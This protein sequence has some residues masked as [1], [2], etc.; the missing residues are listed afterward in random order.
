MSTFSKFSLEKFKYLNC[1][2]CRVGTVWVLQLFLSQSFLEKEQCGTVRKYDSKY[3]RVQM[4]NVGLAVLQIFAEFLG[5]LL[6]S[7]CFRIA[8]IL[9][10]VL[11][12]FAEILSFL[13][14]SVCF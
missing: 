5:F 4:I 14:V 8:N 9:V 12:I 1:F 3:Q 6:V 7:V 10:L 11:Q 2:D 13:L